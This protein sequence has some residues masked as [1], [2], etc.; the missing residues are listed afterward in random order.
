MI[1]TKTQKKLC[2]RKECMTC[3]DKS[4]E[5]HSRG[6]YLSILNHVP[7]IN[8]AKGGRTPY[9]FD[10]D[11]C[12]HSFEM[13]CGR[14]TRKNG[15]QWCSYCAHKKL[16]QDECI[17]C[18]ENSFA[19]NP[20]SIHW[21][22]EGNKD[23]E[24]KKPRDV[25]KGSS[26]IQYSLK[27][28]NCPHFV[29]TE[30]YRIKNKI[31][32]CY[33]AHQELCPNE[34]MMCYENSFASHF[35]SKFLKDKNINT[36][37]IFKYTNDIYAFV[38]ED[39]HEF[40]ARPHD[41]S[42]DHWCSQCYGNK[43]H[44]YEDIKSWIENELSYTL[45]SETYENNR[46]KLKIRCDKG[47]DFEMTW[48]DFQNG[49][50]CGKCKKSKGEKSICEFLDGLGLDYIIQY[51][52]PDCKNINVLPFDVYIPSLNMYIEYDGIQHFE[53]VD[54]FGGVEKF[55][56][57]RFNDKI[58]NE[59]CIK[60]KIVLLRI[61]Y[62]NFNNVKNILDSILFNFIMYYVFFSDELSI[63]QYLIQI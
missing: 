52:N 57:R 62:S 44:K 56:R 54:F 39:G 61:S 34:C 32:C 27:C 6:K 40:N 19:S 63:S 14:V 15:P 48:H 16:C 25:L 5:S 18:Y 2:G 42:H 26:N 38:C 55:E 37:M 3:F 12:P 30:I 23:K 33:C 41:V 60:N 49:S 59:F 53:P 29:E 47:H 10:C 50:R 35:R 21:D 11:K 43:R 1:C 45:I 58:K 9:L 4:M 24:F 22:Y 20:L 13:T 36:R 46:E 7:A 28:P 31:P 8:I 51:R 17:M